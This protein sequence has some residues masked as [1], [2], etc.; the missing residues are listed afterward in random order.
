MTQTYT[1]SDFSQRVHVQQI[2]G[3]IFW[4]KKSACGKT[5]GGKTFVRMTSKLLEIVEI[6]DTG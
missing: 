6:I 1:K 4:G 2:L 3:P 5:G